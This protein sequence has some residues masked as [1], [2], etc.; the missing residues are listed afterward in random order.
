MS[1]RSVRSAP[2]VLALLLVGACAAAEPA[3]SQDVADAAARWGSAP[4]Y[5]LT[6]SADGFEP[7]PMAAGAYGTDG[8]SLIFSDA[9]TGGTFLLTAV[10]GAMR[11][12]DCTGEPIT[13]ASGGSV[14]GA[15]TCAEDGELLR[16]TSGEAEEYVVVRDDVLV[17]VS[18]LAADHDALREA[19]GNV[20]VPTSAELTDLLAEAPPAPGDQPPVER[21]DLPPG[22]GA[23]D[24]GVGAGG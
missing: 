7:V 17:R 9:S 22:D 20:R 19:A 1:L 18:G 11:A 23:P 6:T 12:D 21:G 10:G 16:R 13:D 5:V 15:V 3:A 2:A 4:Q 14:A 8:F 24:N